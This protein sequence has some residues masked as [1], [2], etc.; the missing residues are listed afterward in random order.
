MSFFKH[1]DDC[2][3]VIRRDENGE[4]KLGYIRLDYFKK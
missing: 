2:I 3:G 1:H 4:N